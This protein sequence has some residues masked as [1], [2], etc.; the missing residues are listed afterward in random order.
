MVD[1]VPRLAFAAIDHRIGEI[2]YM[3]RGFPYTRVHEDRGIEAFDVMPGGHCA[4][5]GIF[6]VAEHLNAKRTV[7]PAAVE[8]AIDLGR[9]KNKAAPFGERYDLL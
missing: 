3:T 1:A 9:L 8:P 5:P 4:P 6:Q 7:I 2:L